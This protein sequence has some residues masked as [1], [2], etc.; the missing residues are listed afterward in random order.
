MLR[1]RGER[2]IAANG[3]FSRSA[4]L[5]CLFMHQYRWLSGSSSRTIRRGVVAVVAAV[6]FSSGLFACGEDKAEVPNVVDT[7]LNEAKDQIK[8][9]GFE[10]PKE[11]DALGDRSAMKDSNWVVVAQV[12]APGESVNTDTEITVTIAKPDDDKFLEVAPADSSHAQAVRQKRADDEAERK[13]ADAEAKA[14]ADREAAEKSGEQAQEAKDYV[15]TVDPPAR[16]GKGA[17]DEL[18][19]FAAAAEAG[20]EGDDAVVYYTTTFD[21]VMDSYKTFLDTADNPSHLEDPTDKLKGA[22]EGF[23]RASQTL[24]SLVGTDDAATMQRFR[25]VYNQNRDIYNA[26]L[27]TI[28]ANTGVQPPLIA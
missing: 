25:D 18:S 6:A 8:D 22:V 11:D 15:N 19:V 16:I 27:T 2:A 20:T 12:P 28:Y 13:A 26:A 5:S 21:D 14:K 3:R 9:A 10:D 1:S 24:G 7:R 23:V 17:I 4:G